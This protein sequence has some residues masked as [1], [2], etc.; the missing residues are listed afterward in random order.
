M[1]D[2]KAESPQSDRP[3][4]V[5]TSFEVDWFTAAATSKCNRSESGGSIVA[6]QLYVYVVR[7][8]S[9]TP[10]E[11]WPNADQNCRRNPIFDR[12]NLD[13]GHDDALATGSEA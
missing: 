1:A 2:S 12:S 6:Q 4:R 8:S 3:R 5:L 9:A 7:V 10:A 11:S 13:T